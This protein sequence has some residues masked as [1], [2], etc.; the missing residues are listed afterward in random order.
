MNTI[1]ERASG[2]VRKKQ[3][4]RATLEIISNEGM[5]KLSTKNLAHYVHLS[6][7]AIFR[8]FHSKDEIIL[9][10][11]DDV[12]EDL[13]NALRRIAGKQT[14]PDKRLEEFM[15][16]HVNYLKK[17]SGV[18]I[19]LFTEATYENSELLKKQ[20]NEIFHYIKQY[21]G[22]IVHDGITSG[23]WDNTISVD[24]ISTLY[25][26]IPITMNIEIKLE[27]DIFSYQNFCSQMYHLVSR[28]LVCQN[29][30]S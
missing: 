10:I 27:P 8:H 29:K 5:K 25:I 15:C 21:F 19:L 17:N 30:N 24:A 18:T 20:L 14:P 6:E 16:Y 22:K 1:V 7:G 9:S 28:L 3:I 11:I 26:G 23:I 4:K 2:S 12:K 13:L